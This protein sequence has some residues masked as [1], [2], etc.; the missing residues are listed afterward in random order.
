MTKYTLTLSYSLKSL[1]NILTLEVHQKVKREEEE[2]KDGEIKRG[3]E[4]KG[5]EGRRRKKS[6]CLKKSD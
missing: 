3:C 6:K 2:K 1:P 4:K 5:G